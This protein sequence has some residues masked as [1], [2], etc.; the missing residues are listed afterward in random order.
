MRT[1][2][3]LGILAFIVLWATLTPAVAQVAAPPVLPTLKTFEAG[4]LGLYTPPT[5]VP[6]VPFSDITCT[7]GFDPWIEQFG[8][9]GITAGC[10]GGKYCPGTPVTRDQ[11]AVFIEHA[12]R[13]TSNWPPHTVLVFH[14]PAAEANS[15]VNSGTELLSMVAAIPITGAEAPSSTNPWLVKVGPGIFDLNGAGLYL[16]P[17]VNLDGAGQNSTTIAS[18]NNLIYVV[19]TSGGTN[20]VSNVYLTNSNT[21]ANTYV[22]YALGT[23][24]TL[25]HVH[26]FGENGSLYTIGVFS[27]NSELFIYDS[28]IDAGADTTAYGIFTAGSQGHA[29]QVWRT[30]FSCNTDISNDAGQTIYMAYTQIPD[31]LSNGAGGVY[32]C[33]GNYDG[34]LNPVSCP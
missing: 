19:G 3:R 27:Y 25:D 33:I 20:E 23:T 28:F 10:G 24:L 5:C 14:H 16:A 6:G 30:Q 31:P 34:N 12:M 9:D 8:L 7:T 18:N 11:M 1:L 32:H 22:L 2:S 21:G 29:A 15:N 4:A 17:Y 13:G 26:I